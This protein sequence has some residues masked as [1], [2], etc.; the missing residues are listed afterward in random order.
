MVKQY[1]MHHPLNLNKLSTDHSSSIDQPYG[2]VCVGIKI[3]CAHNQGILHCFSGHMKVLYV[4]HTQEVISC[5][6]EEVAI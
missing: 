2:I 1:C 5:D 4:Q 6:C 3:I